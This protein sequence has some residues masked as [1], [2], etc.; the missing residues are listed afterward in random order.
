M[1]KKDKSQPNKPVKQSPQPASQKIWLIAGGIVLVTLL[2]YI[3]LF[4]NDFLKT[5]DDMAYVTNNELIKDLSANGIARIFKEDGGLY[6]NYH[7]LTTL[8]LALNYHEGVTPFPFQFTNLLLHLLNTALVF[9]FIYLLSDKK[10][11]IATLVSLWFGVHPMHVESVAWIS[12]RKDVLYTFFFLTGLI[13]YWRYITSNFALKWYILTMLL[14][15]LSM[16][17]KAMAASFPVVLLC[18]DYLVK[19]KFNIRLIA[20]KIPFV[21]YAIVMGIIAIKMQAAGNATTAL[22]FPA[23]SRLLHASYGFTMYISKMLVPTGLSAFYPYPYPLTNSYWNIDIIPSEL[24]TTFAVT[25]AIVAAV[26]YIAVKKTFLSRWILFGMGFYLASIALVLQYFPVG[27][28]II[29]DRYSY[30]P[31]IGLFCIIGAFI[32]HYIT[33]SDTK[34]M[35]KILLGAAGIYSLVL[36]YKTYRQVQVWKN[37]DTL[38]SNTI[39]KYPGDNRLVLSYFNR[40]SYYYMQN[41]FDAALNDFLVISEQNSKDDNVMV[42][43]G[44]IYGQQKNDLNNA[45]VYFRKAYEVNPQNTEAL[46]YLATAYGLKGD[47]TTSLAYAQ[48]AI[49][50]SPN[51]PDLYINAA[52]SLHNLGKVEEE[53]IYKNKAEEL[54]R[55]R[56]N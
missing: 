38:W 15:A 6:A 10:I 16:L 5:W 22:T 24:Y 36:C 25:L 51:D 3:P 26:V 30:V 18:V 53:A 33:S 7:P 2:C 28:A 21:A 12:E 31:Y 4:D 34:Q 32:Q 29:S 43:I 46:K 44:T 13:T 17:S 39:K 40:A 41:K 9:V 45:I 55:Q 50:L 19:R 54:K 23:F 37:D 35:G 52:V 8:S 49:K 48:E 56:G 1:K 42:R 27:R 14:F 20:E 11:I 47:F